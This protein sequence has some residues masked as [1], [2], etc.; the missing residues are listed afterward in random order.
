MLIPDNTDIITFI[1]K[2]FLQNTSG[3]QLITTQSVRVLW[4]DSVG[5]NSGNKDVKNMNKQFDIFIK[6]NVSHNADNDRLRM[7]HDLIANRLRTLLTKQDVV[8]NMRFKY[9]DEYHLWTKI[10]GY[11]RYHV[12]FSYKKTV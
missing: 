11:R 12:V 5:S 3:D 7:R 4:Y 2:Y 1:D 6:D 8:C 10:P 9:E